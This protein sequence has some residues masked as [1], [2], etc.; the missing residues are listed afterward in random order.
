[1]DLEKVDEKLL[2]EFAKNML[3]IEYLQVGNMELK[4]HIL[5]QSKTEVD[6]SNKSSEKPKQKQ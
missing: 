2:V 3:M 1:M 5:E 4:R 6:K